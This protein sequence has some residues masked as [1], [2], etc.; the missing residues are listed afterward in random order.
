VWSWQKN[1]TNLER[2][3]GSGPPA[4]CLPDI[5]TGF[6]SRDPNL[7]YKRSLER[8]GGAQSENDTGRRSLQVGEKMRN[9]LW[10]GRRYRYRFLPQEAG[11]KNHLH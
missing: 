6:G 9:Y 11:G 2:A 5:K 3:A 10:V 1:E 4:S 7:G 8:Q